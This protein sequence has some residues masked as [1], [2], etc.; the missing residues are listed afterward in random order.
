MDLHQN[1]WTKDVKGS[2]RD[3]DNRLMITKLNRVTFRGICL[4]EQS[5]IIE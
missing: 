2:Q 5:L 3:N 1:C 4:G